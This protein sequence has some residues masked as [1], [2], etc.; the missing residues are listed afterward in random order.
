M[1]LADLA[2]LRERLPAVD[3]DIQHQLRSG[4]QGMWQLKGRLESLAADRAEKAKGQLAKRA[5]DEANA[6]KVLHE[7]RERILKTRPRQRR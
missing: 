5:E 2:S 7:Q 4:C 1:A 3:E 6:Q